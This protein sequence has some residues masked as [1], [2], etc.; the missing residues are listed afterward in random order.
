MSHVPKKRQ[1]T[2]VTMQNTME[3]LDAALKIKGAADWARDLKLFRTAL[4]SAKQRGNLSPSIAYALAEEM[5]QDADTWALIAAAESERD[6]A[7]KD[8][9]KKRLAVRLASLSIGG[10][11]G[12][13]TLDEALHP[14]LP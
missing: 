5:G 2:E 12:I 9:M 11:G 3:L 10:N 8:R 4:H 7:C 6:S 13:R 14:I 1:K